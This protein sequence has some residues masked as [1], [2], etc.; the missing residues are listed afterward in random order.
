MLG[1]VRQR[2]NSDWELASDCYWAYRFP[3]KR[4]QR[5][6]I[7]SCCLVSHT[8]FPTVILSKDPSDLVDVNAS[9]HFSAHLDG[10][11]DFVGQWYN[12]LRCLNNIREANRLAPEEE[13]T[14]ASD[15]KRLIKARY[16]FHTV[17][18][19]DLLRLA[20]LSHITSESKLTLFVASCGK[21]S[22]L[23]WK[24]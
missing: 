3:L 17:Q 15:S 12:L 14:L 13:C 10:C 19:W 21:H 9:S 7:Y 22:A 23:L 16:R 2:R 18:V 6:R 1:C 5:V 8:K 24:E 20:C 4:D 11:C